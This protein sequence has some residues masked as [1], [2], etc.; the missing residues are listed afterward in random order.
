[1]RRYALVF[2]VNTFIALVLQTLLTII[3]VDSAGLGLEIFLQFLIYAS[4]FAVIAVIF[5]IA[6][7][8]KLYKRRGPERQNEIPST[9][10]VP[11]A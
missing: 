2:G 3:V 10:T 7:L 11:E 9:E 8:Y 1:M 4:Y 6:W 5:L